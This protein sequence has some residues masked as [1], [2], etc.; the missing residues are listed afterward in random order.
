MIHDADC[1]LIPVLLGTEGFCDLATCAK[2]LP[3]R[4]RRWCSDA[5]SRFYTDAIYGQHDWNLARHK[6]YLRDERK[7]VKCGAP[8]TLIPAKTKWGSPR[9]SLEV[10]HIV[11]RNGAGYG[12]GCHHH[13]SNLETLCHPCHVQVTNAQRRDRAA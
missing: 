3:K 11:P 10:N 8:E 2:P 9:S 13:L 12:R 6:A 1:P 7:C 4:R 5:C